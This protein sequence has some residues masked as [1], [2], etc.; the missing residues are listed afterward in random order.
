[1]IIQ[2]I[3]AFVA[4]LGFGMLFGLR[5]K[6]LFIGAFGGLLSWLCCLLV[7]GAQE[8]AYIGYLAAGA[9]CSLFGEICARIFKAPATVFCIPAI[10]PLVPGNSLYRTMAAIVVK[11]LDGARAFGTAT[12]QYAFSIAAGVSVIWAA[13]VI[14]E[15]IFN[16]KKKKKGKI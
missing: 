3:C 8:D 4:T 2:L 9:F 16:R 6:T 5:G 7:M 15:N 11:D 12:A 1:M 10:V 14:A 13:F